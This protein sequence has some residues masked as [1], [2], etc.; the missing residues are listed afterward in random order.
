MGLLGR[1]V[2]LITGTSDLAPDEVQDWLDSVSD[3]GEGRLEAYATYDEFYDGDYKTPLRDRTSRVLDRHGIGF[4]E[5]F[6]DVV[7][8]VLAE[9]LKV[10]GFSTS[11]A[12]ADEET[13][14][15]NDPIGSQIEEWW[16]ACC[17]DGLQMTT[18]AETLKL[19]DG[20]LA[21]DWNAKKGRP[22]LCFNHP[23]MVKFVYHDDAPDELAY[24]SKL[25]STS[26]PEPG[27]APTEVQRLNIYW[28]DRIEKWYRLHNGMGGMQGGWAQWVD[29]DPDTGAPEAWPVDWTNSAGDPL[30]IP[31]FHVKH[32]AQSRT[33]GRSRLR[34]V[35]PFQDE[36]NK[37]VVDLNE[38]IDAHPAPQRWAS[39]VSGDLDLKGSPG[40]V[41]KASG[42]ASKFG[43]F[44]PGDT[45]H[46]LNAIEGVLSRL[47]RATRVPMHLLTGGENPSGEALKSAESG[48]VA[49]AES[50]QVEFGNAWEGAVM[51]AL[52]LAAENGYE[53]LPAIPDDLTIEVQWDN[54]E[55]RSGKE[56]LEAAMLKKQVG[57]SK[58]TLIRE[59]G[60][61]PEK[62]SERR[63][64]ESKQEAEA[65]GKFLD[66][67]GGGFE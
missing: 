42:E 60:Y 66:S 31:L 51:M 58:Y 16:Q 39:G 17:W 2:A 15:V 10:V 8:D 14:E 32:R 26:R 44:A 22:E 64:E 48:L 55:T 21:V 56:D 43:E 49:Q 6:S 12:E 30:G 52:K 46:L 41:W 3:M 38:L 34:S 67:G 1:L 33:Y 29:T 35:I 7:V 36:L 25:W 45:A 65:M 54:P 24:V 50:V 5:N 28:P 19:G 27:Q 23:R 62:E 53:G 4:K 63:G 40:S 61:D 47:A 20:A 37:I 9:R 59:L 13:G 57:I 18:H 11:D